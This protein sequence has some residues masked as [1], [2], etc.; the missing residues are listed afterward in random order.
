MRP[1]T[2]SAQEPYELTAD[3]EGL[4]LEYLRQPQMQLVITREQ[5]PPGIPVTLLG[6][7]VLQDTTL[8]EALYSQIGGSYSLTV[9]DRET[10]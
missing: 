1:I 10:R 4:G 8:R 9:F 2:V 5:L 6:T 7:Y 3:M